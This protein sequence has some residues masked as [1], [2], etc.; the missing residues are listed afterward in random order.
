ML[1]YS[2]I[3]AV[4]V[5]CCELVSCGPANNGQALMVLAD[6]MTYVSGNFRRQR[7]TLDFGN[8]KV[9]VQQSWKEVGVAAV[10]WDAVSARPDRLSDKYV[11]Q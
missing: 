5:D 8:V 7:R 10:V 11:H 3:L 9:T 4:V 2:I 1:L 6:D